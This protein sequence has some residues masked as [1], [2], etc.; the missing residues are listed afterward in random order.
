M[1]EPTGDF[2]QT[3]IHLLALADRLEGHGQYN[4]AKLARASAD[5]LARRAAYELNLPSDPD[6]LISDLRHMVAA[7]PAFG[8]GEDLARA[9]GRGVDA[10]ADGRLP[11]I[12][13]T[14]T[15][16]VCRTCGA[17]A[18]EQPASPC[19]TCGAWPATF[20]RFQPVYWLDDLRPKEALALLGSTPEVIAGMLA[21]L[22]EEHMARPAPDGGWSI[23]QI[24]SHMRD[25]EG[26][27]RARLQLMVERDDPILESL[28]V[29]AWAADEEN[30]PPATA[31]IFQT[32]WASRRESVDLLES[33]PGMNW[34]RAGHHKEF[35]RVTILQQASYFALHE[36]THL[37]ALGTLV[38]G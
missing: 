1:H 18:M 20:Q 21:G 23:R 7:L 30:R 11:L 31:E 14:P 22:S 26:V 19:A 38:N 12:D 33:L 5:S 28:A 10:M 34:Y 17:L 29:F 2:A 13:E 32:Y 27:L 35:G 4:N 6:D 15:P 9:A 8:L 37:A 25:A 16:F 3:I 24:V 36:Q